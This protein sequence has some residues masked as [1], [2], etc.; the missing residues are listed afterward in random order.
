MREKIGKSNPVASVAVENSLSDDAP[1]SGSASG[2]YYMRGMEKET[3]LGWLIAG[4]IV[5]FGTKLAK[6]QTGAAPVV[7]VSTSTVMRSVTDEYVPGW[8]RESSYC[9]TRREPRRRG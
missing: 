1:T 3:D 7:V 8:F 9:G 6:R 4:N 2:K 5:P